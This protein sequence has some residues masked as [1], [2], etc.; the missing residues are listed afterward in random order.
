MTL[1]ADW[2]MADLPHFLPFRMAYEVNHN[3]PLSYLALSRPDKDNYLLRFEVRRNHP[4]YKPTGMSIR[5]DMNYVEAS[6]PDPELCVIE[7]MDALIS[8]M[9][10]RMRPHTPEMMLQEYAPWMNSPNCSHPHPKIPP[11]AD[12]SQPEP[13]QE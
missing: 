11:S 8:V 9:S 7:L 5:I 12:T 4:I 3:F 2:S 1:A 13:T 6:Y 10:D